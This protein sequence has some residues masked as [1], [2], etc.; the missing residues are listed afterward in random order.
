MVHK[1]LST[2]GPIATELT[3]GLPVDDSTRKLD[4]SATGDT[5]APPHTGDTSASSHTGN[6]TVHGCEHAVPIFGALGHVEPMEG[7][8][9]FLLIIGLIIFTEFLTEAMESMSK[10]TPFQKMI[11]NIEKELM[12]IGF[13]SFMFKIFMDKI[14]LPEVWKLPLEFSDTVI[15]MVTFS[16]CLQ[17]I[18]LVFMSLS[19]SKVWGRAYNVKLVEIVHDYHEVMKKSTWNP[20]ALIRSQTI[21]NSQLEFLIH[22]DA[23]W[24]GYKITRKAFPFDEY[25]DRMME[26]FMSAVT[27]VRLVD[28]LILVVL[29]LANWVRVYTYPPYEHCELLESEEEKVLCKNYHTIVTFIA[30]GVV[31]FVCTGITAG[32]SRLYE[33]RLLFRDETILHIPTDAMSKYVWDIHE[34]LEADLGK[35]EEEIVAKTIDSEL[36]T[37]SELKLAMQKEKLIKSLEEKEEVNPIEW[38]I[39][40]VIETMRNI[41]KCLLQTF[42]CRADKSRR[43]KE[44][45]AEHKAKRLAAIKKNTAELA[46]VTEEV[47]GKI[48]SIA[49]NALKAVK[50]FAVH[51]EV[52]STKVLVTKADRMLSPFSDHKPLDRL[53]FAGSPELYFEWVMFVTL[54]I[55]AYWAFW[56]SNMIDA[57][58]PEGSSH[59]RALAVIP[60]IACSLLNIYV[61][62][63]AALM[64]ALVSVD[65]SAIEKV[66]EEME[67]DKRVIEEV[68][69]KILAKL[70]DMKH[71]RASY[72]PIIAPVA[73][74]EAEKGRTVAFQENATVE[75]SADQDE[76]DVLKELQA[77]FTEINDGEEVKFLRFE[78]LSKQRL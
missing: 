58:Q 71:S 35:S 11:Y 39:E 78:I 17:G 73:A 36:L 38:L 75:R 51:P 45:Q 29:C 34:H 66:I 47:V 49:G 25:V 74:Q 60:G 65:S 16:F 56:L 10:D 64:K 7:T 33:L 8:A 57:P 67:N 76:I 62:R 22:E 69:E 20:L 26:R 3:N 13:M 21:F 23:F 27:T 24:V 61:C 19:Q 5:S 46:N 40:T 48:D 2:V 50:R 4:S 18:L 44:S 63:T 30:F 1:T 32:V 12:T 55:S 72:N 14:E 28:W 52:S 6:S 43:K 15:P 9:S 70:A 77:S 53:F 41:P 68:R 54:L 37:A 59:L 42:F 31:L